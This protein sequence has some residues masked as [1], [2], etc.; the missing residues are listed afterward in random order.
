MPCNTDY[1]EPTPRELRMQEEARWKAVND[2]LTHENDQL[3]EM[4]LRIVVDPS[5]KIPKQWIKKVNADQIKHRKEDLA[6]LKDTFTK[7]KDAE[8]L[9]KVI[10]ADPNLPLEEQLGFDPDKY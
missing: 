4:L 6:R 1:M 7:S 9:G 2:R 3:R 10:L 5:Y 8:K